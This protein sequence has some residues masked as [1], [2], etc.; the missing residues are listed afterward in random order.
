MTDQHAREQELLERVLA[1]FDGAQD[2][3]LRQVMQALV[4]HLHAFLR[5]VRLTE[6][7]WLTAI[8]FLTAAGEITDSRR[9]EF[10]LLSDVLGASM[11]TITI[12]NEA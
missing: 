6:D 2:P 9:Q 7:E 11:Q 1:S 4:R 3:R 8:R 5:E 10:I 12:N